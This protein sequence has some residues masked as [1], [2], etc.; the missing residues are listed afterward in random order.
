M[1]SAVEVLRNTGTLREGWSSHSSHI[2]RSQ[3]QSL[4]FFFA[5]LSSSQRYFYTFYPAAFSEMGYPRG[6]SG[7]YSL[8][9]SC[10]RNFLNYALDLLIRTKPSAVCKV[11]SLPSAQTALTHLLPPGT[12]GHGHGPAG[13]QP[14]PH[15]LHCP[16][17]L[18][19][20]ERQRKHSTGSAAHRHLPQSA[21]A[22]ELHPGSTTQ[23][24]ISQGFCRAAPRY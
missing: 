7:K 10:Q 18:H 17:E 5:F 11:I 23:H 6:V 24:T 12:R 22:R 21:P 20:G 16:A 2:P 19:P 8:F 15:L 14:V 1:E 9:Y 13:R 3:S 4:K